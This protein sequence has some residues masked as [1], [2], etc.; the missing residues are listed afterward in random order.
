MVTKFKTKERKPSAPAVV[1]KPVKAAGVSV[2]EIVFLEAQQRALPKLDD[3]ARAAFAGRFSDA[4]CDGLGTQTQSALVVNEAIGA[5]GVALRNF[6]SKPAP[7]AYAPKRLAWLVEC[8]LSLQAARDE[9]QKQL[10]KVASVIA[11]VD[12]ARL[13]TLAARADLL[14][15]L[16][17]L[18]GAAEADALAAARGVTTPDPEIVKSCQSLA[19]LGRAWLARAERDATARVLVECAGLTSA[20]VEQVA[21]DAKAFEA[22]RAGKPLEG[23]KRPFDTPPVNRAEGRVLEELRA[24]MSA[25]DAAHAKNN[26]VERWIPGAGTRRVLAP[27]SRPKKAAPAPPA[28]AIPAPAGK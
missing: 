15:A 3:V 17:Q 14:T 4:H 16:E 10:G 27:S 1:A 28:P 21:E 12:K 23:A 26:L 2:K 19:N 7:M 20:M 8:T 13:S 6:A 25:F 9:Q 11:D 5:I 24:L 22:A 18:A